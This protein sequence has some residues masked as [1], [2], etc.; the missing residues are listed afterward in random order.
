[1]TRQEK[2]AAAEAGQLACTATL[3]LLSIVRFGDGQAARDAHEAEA[4][5]LR[6]IKITMELAGFHPDEEERGAL[7]RAIADYI[8]TL[9][10][11]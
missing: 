9:G 7:Y 2:A 8:S 3:D 4:H 1:M 10:D 11:D 5:L 6:A